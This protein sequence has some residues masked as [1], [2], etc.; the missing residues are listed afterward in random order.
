MGTILLPALI[1]AAVGLIAGIILTI[2]SR[3]MYVPVDERITA[4][5]EVLPGANCGA[6]G[7]AGCSDYAAAMVND[8]DVGTSLC[9]VG[10][11][12]VSEKIAEIL[13]VQ[14]G[15]SEPKTAMVMCNGTF[16]AT[17]QIG[18]LNRLHTCRSAKMFY[19]GNWACPYGC[20]GLGDCKAACAFDAIRIIDGV[21]KVDRTK[22]VACEACMKACPNG[23]ISMVSKKKMVY[24][25][26]SSME[27]GA[28]TRK[29]CTSG[30][31]G[32]KKC[33]KVCKFDA[34]KVEN[35]LASIAY[36]K[37]V[38]CGLCAKECPTGAIINLRKIKSAADAVAA[39]N[40]GKVA[41]SAA[42]SADAANTGKPANASAPAASAVAANTAADTEDTAA[43][44]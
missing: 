39:A 14:S 30:C 19:G 31:I 36:D 28:K 40:A 33:E 11:T 9:P 42:A 18:E 25:A 26:C 6:C 2:A 7:F 22:C 37:C 15:Y 17:H 20:L 16:T 24:V 32:C 12:A 5:E 27:K 3:L 43:Q 38:N 8:P 34:V 29:T 35:N 23:I 4:L 13:G 41:K 10:G 21:A 44:A 1:V